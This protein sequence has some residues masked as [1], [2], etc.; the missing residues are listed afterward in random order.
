MPRQ[1]KELSTLV[2]GSAPQTGRD[3]LVDWMKANGE[4][5]S[6][7]RYLELAYPEGVPSPLP[8]EIEADL[9]SEL[10]R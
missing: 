7:R 4:P 9:P 3:P 6:V 10:S 2:A 1:S 8:P 5:L